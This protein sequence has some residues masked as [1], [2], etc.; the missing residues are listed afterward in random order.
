MGKKYYKKQENKKPKKEVPICG[1][2]LLDPRDSDLI[3]TDF[4]WV[5]Q[6][7]YYSLSC[8]N[9]IEELN[10]IVVKPYQKKRGRGKKSD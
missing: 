2:C 7:G 4:Y 1:D 8:K 10:L 3:P 5:Q 6:D 9:C